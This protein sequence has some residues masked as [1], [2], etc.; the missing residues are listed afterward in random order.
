LVVACQRAPVLLVVKEPQNDA[1][2]V[3]AE[4]RTDQI[5]KLVEPRAMPKTK[6]T[7]VVSMRGL[8]IVQFLTGLV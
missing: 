8:T 4:L 1:V 7:D 5:A 3:E 2:A 6:P